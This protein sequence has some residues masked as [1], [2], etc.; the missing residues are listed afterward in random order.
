MRWLAILLM[1]VGCM[2]PVTLVRADEPDQWFLNGNGPT[3]KYQ[4]FEFTDNGEP[5]FVTPIATPTAPLVHLAWPSAIRFGTGVG[6]WPP[7]MTEPR[8]ARY[9][10]GYRLTKGPGL[11][12]GPGLPPMHRNRMGWV[13][14]TC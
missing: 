2:L 11:Q 9:T 6:S 14:P 7:G 1:L 13:Q 5:R 8:G 3:E 12:R 10:A 4:I